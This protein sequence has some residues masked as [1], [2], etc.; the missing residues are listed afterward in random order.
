MNMKKTK[1]M[2]NNHI[3]EHGIKIHDEVIECIQK[4]SAIPDHKQKMKRGIRMRWSIFSKQHNVMK[5]NFPLSL[6]RRV[7][8][9]CILTYR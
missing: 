2:F 3:L 9:Q 1:M 4:I 8:N 5:N 7:Y 6:Q